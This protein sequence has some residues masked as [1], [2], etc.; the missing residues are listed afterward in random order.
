MRII[1]LFGGV[2]LLILIIKLFIF[3]GFTLHEKKSSVPVVSITQVKQVQFQQYITENGTLKSLQSVD[4][5]ADV[6]AKISQIFFV[7]GQHVKA[8]DVLFI[9]SHEEISAEIAEA[10]AK[11]VYLKKNF[12]RYALLAKKEMISKDYL[13]NLQSQLDQEQAKLRGLYAHLEKHIVRAP[14]EGKLGITQA[15]IGKYLKSGEKVV[16]LQNDSKNVIDLILPVHVRNKITLGQ[17]V[18]VGEVHDLCGQIA[19]FDTA[20]DAQTHGLTVRI[21]LDHCHL[22]A[23]LGGS[24]PVFL[25]TTNERALAVPTTALHYSANGSAIYRVNANHVQLEPVEVEIDQDQA[26]LKKGNMVA[27]EW[28]VS[29]GTEKI[30]DGQIIKIHKQTLNDT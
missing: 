15:T 16:N 20:I 10:E 19:A 29:T 14:F 21:T 3:D 9:Q 24:V 12:Q 28:V 7:S 8:G 25:F 30:T 6:P 27:G 23:V 4:I 11:W 5:V 22:N 17:R 1:L 13:D 18:A 2:I 26:I